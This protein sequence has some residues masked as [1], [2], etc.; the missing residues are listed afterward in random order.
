MRAGGHPMNDS[1]RTP[2]LR[3]SA[4]ALVFVAAVAV[5]VGMASWFPSNRL[6]GG[7]S[8]EQAIAAAASSFPYADAQFVSAHAGRLRDFEPEGS[9]APGDDNDAV[10]ALA[11]SGSFPRCGAPS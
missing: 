8:R 9:G 10:W 11:Y 7:I 5:A 1:L 3:A 6:G 2:L 4:L